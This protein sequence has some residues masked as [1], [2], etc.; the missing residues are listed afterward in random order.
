[1]DHLMLMRSGTLITQKERITKAYYFPFFHKKNK[2]LG[3]TIVMD[4]KAQRELQTSNYSAMLI[5]PVF[6]LAIKSYLHVT[7]KL[8]NDEQIKDWWHHIGNMLGN[9]DVVA[10]R[11][12]YDHMTSKPAPVRLDFYNQ[13][14]QVPSPGNR[15][16]LSRDIDALGMQRVNIHWQLGDIDRRTFVK[17]QELMAL[18]AG[19]TGFGRVRLDIRETDSL[20][21][22]VRG[23]NHQLGTTRMHNDESQGVVDSNCRLHSVANLYVAGGSVFPTCGS[24]NPTLTVVALAL[25]L[26]DHLKEIHHDE[27]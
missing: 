14:E 1:M 23:D 9:L 5:Q 24:T 26:A 22:S 3:L 20:L 16:T 7:R 18:E 21:E 6:S 10:N 15:I 12:Y 27:N 2:P 25:R 11:F 13:W 4:K 19:R 8:E 17:A